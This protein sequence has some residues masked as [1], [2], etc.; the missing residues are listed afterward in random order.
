[1]DNWACMLLR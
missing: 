1:M